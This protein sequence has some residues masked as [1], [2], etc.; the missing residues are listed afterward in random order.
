VKFVPADERMHELPPWLPHAPD[1]KQGP[2][3]AAVRIG[4]D[5]GNFA[6]LH[7]QTFEAIRS[8]ATGMPSSVA[9]EGEATTEYT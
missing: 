4:E 1:D 9:V 2:D 8:F 6:E 7:K 5:T 3:E